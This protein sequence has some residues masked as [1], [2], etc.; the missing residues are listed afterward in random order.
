MKMYHI[1]CKTEAEKKE[2]IELF[3]KLGYEDYNTNDKYL[4]LRVHKY[5]EVQSVLHFSSAIN[6]GSQE[7]TLQQLREMAE[8]KMKEYLTKNFD[9]RYRLVNHCFSEDDIEVPEGANAFLKIGNK[10]NYFYSFGKKS[11]VIYDD[12]KRESVRDG[13]ETADEFMSF[14]D[15]SENSILWQRPKLPEELP[16]IDDEPKDN[17]NH[18]QHYTSGDIECIDAIKASMSAEAFKGF[19]KG[20]VLK[21][22]WRYEHKGGK[23]S[24]EKAQW[25]LNK[26]I[27][28]V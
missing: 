11:F 26:L 6:E 21:Y 4:K 12:G 9:G 17:V 1:D 25:Y 13:V 27:S 19:L 22:M 10:G 14:D 3:E 16:F 23:E 24:L 2:S 15:F 8:P 18:P 5:G 28:L 7:V 20:N